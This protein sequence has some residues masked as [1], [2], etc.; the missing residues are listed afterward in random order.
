MK[1]KDPRQNGAYVARLPCGCTMGV[2]T[3]YRDR[4]TGQAVAEWI[5]NGLIVNHVTWEEYRDQIC[6]EPT[7]M[8]CPHGQLSLL[9]PTGE[10]P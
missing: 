4:A 7:F 9:T 2:S 6:K 8:E 10:Q 5:A 1:E 3:D